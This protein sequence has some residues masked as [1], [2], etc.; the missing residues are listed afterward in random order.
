[1]Q[2]PE[3]PA[4]NIAMIFDKTFDQ[5]VDFLQWLLSKIEHHEYVLVAIQGR[6]WATS[7]AENLVIFNH[8]KWNVWGIQKLIMFSSTVLTV[9]HKH[10]ILKWRQYN[11]ERPWKLNFLSLEIPQEKHFQLLWI[12][13][14]APIPLS[15]GSIRA[16]TI[17]VGIMKTN[18]SVGSTPSD[19]LWPQTSI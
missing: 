2:H 1:M 18:V 9:H 16:K 14:N 15:P 7:D 10:L 8:W 11:K 12:L 4:D 6:P 3:S 13:A 17:S 5:N 19:Q